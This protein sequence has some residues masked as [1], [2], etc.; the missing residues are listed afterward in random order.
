MRMFLHMLDGLIDGKYNFHQSWGGVQFYKISR[1][2]YDNY[3][4]KHVD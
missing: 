2:L 4:K 3:P 1:V